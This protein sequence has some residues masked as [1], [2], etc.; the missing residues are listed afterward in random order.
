MQ[1][2]LHARAR[3]EDDVVLPLRR[4]PLVRSGYLVVSR[5][6]GAEPEDPVT[7]AAGST[8]GTRLDIGNGDTRVGDD[9]VCLGDVSP[10][11]S[12]IRLR[13]RWRAAEQGNN[14]E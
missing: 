3:Q 2:D 7:I 11:L 10:N 6:Q 8:F 4:K 9:A 1:L 13:K 5:R 12:C 14:G